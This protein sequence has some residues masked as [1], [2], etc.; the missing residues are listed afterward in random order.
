M[1]RE[2]RKKGDP[3]Q[4]ES[5]PGSSVLAAPS[6]A[7]CVSAWGGPRVSVASSLSLSRLHF[8]YSFFRLRS[9]SLRDKRDESVRWSAQ[10]PKTPPEARSRRP[11]AERDLDLDGLREW[12]RRWAHTASVGWL[13][14]GGA[15]VGSLQRGV[16]ALDSG[17]GRPRRPPA[18]Q[19]PASQASRGSGSVSSD[20]GV[21]VALRCGIWP[22]EMRGNKDQVPSEACDVK[23]TLHS[24]RVS[25][26]VAARSGGTDRRC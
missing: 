14:A 21:D 24:M 4:L 13:A 22:Q 7:C 9:L 15:V 1:V 10:P 17:A 6:P 19:Q 23:D 8:C 16:A 12:L 11:L 20:G 18:S 25:R 3:S 5:C 26:D 2:R